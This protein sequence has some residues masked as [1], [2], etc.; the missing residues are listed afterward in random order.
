MTPIKLIIPGEVIPQLRPRFRRRGNYVQ[1][2]DPAKCRDYKDY[3]RRLASECYKDKPL[4]GAV[5][6][7]ILIHRHTPKS[8]GKTK[9]AMAL[10]GA[11]RPTTKPDIENLSK[12]ILDALN[13]I[14]WRD[15][16]QIVRLEVEKWYSDQPRAEV[17]VCEL[18]E[19]N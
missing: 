8:F 12:G 11:L 3:I 13:G 15:D 19:E 4:D 1:T 9:M 2:Y 18:R 5:E 14:V 17:L 6:V 10:A 7:K 16:A